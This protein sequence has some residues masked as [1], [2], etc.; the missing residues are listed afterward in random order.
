M[1][2]AISL[3]LILNLASGSF[4][5]EKKNR[6]DSTSNT[7]VLPFADNPFSLLP[8]LSVGVPGVADTLLM[9]VDLGSNQTSVIDVNCI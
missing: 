4:Q 1:K 7:M 9:Q 5:L 6:K 8:Q 2:L 3:A